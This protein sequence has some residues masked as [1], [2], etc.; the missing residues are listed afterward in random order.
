[1][2]RDTLE[3]E[4][5]GERL[6]SLSYGEID[7]ASK[8]SHPNIVSIIDAGEE[9][10][11]GA[12]EGAPGLPY[13]V[14][15]YVEGVDAAGLLKLTK[16]RGLD[17]RHVAYIVVG[18]AQALAY[19]HHEAVIHRDVSRRR[20]RQRQRAGEARRLRHRQDAAVSTRP[21]SPAASSARTPTWPPSC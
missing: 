13:V 12:P 20:S 2:R 3:H 16:P 6:L 10:P 17:P 1:M 21:P 8:L 18:A 15:E 11:E 14:M 9:R 5:H 7:L 19:A 4:E